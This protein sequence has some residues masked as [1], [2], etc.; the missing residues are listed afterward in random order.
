MSEYQYYEWLAIDQAL[1][2]A[3]LREVKQLSSHMD[4]VTPTN[5]VVTYSYGDFKHDPIKVLA[6]HFDAF[7][8]TSNWGTRTLAFRFPK[9]S[10]NMANLSGYL[11]TD[12]V[13]LEK[14]GKYQVL[15][16]HIDNENGDWIEEY[17]DDSDGTLS[18]LAGVR[19]QIALGDHRALY[20]MWLAALQREGASETNED[21]DDAYDGELPDEPPIP[22]GLG[23]LD[24]SLT[25]FCD[26]FG[27]DPHLVTA[28]AQDSPAVTDIS[29]ADVKAA[30]AKLSRATCDGLLLRLFE[31]EPQLGVKL[32]QQ[33][34][35][36]P[37]VPKKKARQM[38]GRSA[39]EL[40]QSA[41][42]IAEQAKQRE[43]ARVQAAR[44]KALE[45]L[46]TT[47]DEAWREVAELLDRKTAAGYTGA[48]KLLVDLRDMAQH[49]GT[50]QVFERQL[51]KIRAKYGKSRVF[52]TRL[53][54]AGLV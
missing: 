12:S 50:P 48:V 6:L 25:A 16:F 17:E 51:T 24:A 38:P 21:Y 29:R 30:I 32:R 31:E 26:F 3:G 34:F 36:A 8:Y 44:I 23:S 4:H 54:K 33:L 39:A 14:H 11:M 28:A 37:S 49:K 15:S 10:F 13:E 35:G 20:L 43:K 18:T 5:A 27:I 45:K 42:R 53:A 19:R 9:D 46:A 7:L 2:G 47:S 41:K 52:E 22:P 40:L 1:D